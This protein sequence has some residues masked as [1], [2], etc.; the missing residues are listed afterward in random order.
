MGD[1]S[2][3]Y[4][5]FEECKFMYDVVDLE[6]L[7]KN[8]FSVAVC[9]NCGN[10]L[11]YKTLFGVGLATKLQIECSRPS[12]LKKTSLLHLKWNCVMEENR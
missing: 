6:G 1:F 12:C 4:Q 11:I 7:L 2:V 8:I 3:E 10:A 9:K 5:Q